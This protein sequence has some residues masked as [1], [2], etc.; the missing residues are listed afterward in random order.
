MLMLLGRIV[1][2]VLI[3]LWIIWKLFEG[4]RD[5]NLYVGRK[6][7]SQSYIYVKRSEEPG[8]YWYWVF[9]HIFFGIFAALI[10]FVI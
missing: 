4:F 9:F 3:E 2:I 7:F 5:G 6:G 1:V 10:I 8:R